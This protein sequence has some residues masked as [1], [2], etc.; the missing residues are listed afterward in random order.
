M[1]V[2]AIM[3]K[4]THVTFANDLRDLA[5]WVESHP[6]LQIP[7]LDR[8]DIFQRLPLYAKAMG[9]VEKEA[10]DSFFMLRKNFGSIQLEVNWWREQVCE[11]VKVG[12]KVIPEQI[13]PA[14]SEEIIPEHVE[15]VYEWKCPE[16]ILTGKKGA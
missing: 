2:E 3:D 5:D 14:K 1:R 10:D 13:L 16:S 4:R 6:E 9:T 15:N 8:V 12:E 7:G 11:R